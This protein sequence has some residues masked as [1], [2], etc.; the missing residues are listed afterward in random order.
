MIETVPETGSTNADLLARVAAG[1]TIS[2]GFWLRAERQTSGR[3]RLGREWHS[4][5]GNLY[6]STVISL[7]PSDP[8]PATLSFVAGLALHD[9]A[10]RCFLDH[11]P[12]LLKWPNDLLVREAKIAGILLEREGDHV[13]AGF[14]MN[15][16]HSPEIAGRKTTHI[17]FENGKFANGPD[18]VLDMLAPAMAQRVREWREL[19]LTHTLAE[20]L[21]RSHRF[22]DRLRVVNGDGEPLLGSFRGLTPDGALRLQPIGAAECTIHAGDVML[23]WHDVQPD[24]NTTDHSEDG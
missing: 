23:D 20:W 2:E 1:D 19:P 8:A 21:V 22:D 17:A 12:M 7:R 14:G 16:G 13:I 11:T 15:V 10:M 6:C 24:A 5:P 4:G 18:S 9:V 3:G